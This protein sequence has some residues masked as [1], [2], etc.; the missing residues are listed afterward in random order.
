M[1]RLD[2][3]AKNAKVLADLV[4]DPSTA[5]A[6]QVRI[7]NKLLEG[8]RNPNFFLTMYEAKMSYGPCPHCGHK[9]HWLIPEN[10]LNQLNHVTA[11]HDD[12][13]KRETTEEDCKL[14]AE[15]CGK[16]KVNC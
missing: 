6:L 9:N 5:P 15:A 14:F 12:R 1:A 13:V 11:E 16:R 7:L 3:T 4:V 10:N 2:E 8:R